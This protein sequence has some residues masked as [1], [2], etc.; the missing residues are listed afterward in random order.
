MSQRPMVKGIT[1]VIGL[2]EAQT[3]LVA[4]ARNVEVPVGMM[5]DAE[6]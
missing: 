2:M 4:P 3:I 6:E 1:D 5:V